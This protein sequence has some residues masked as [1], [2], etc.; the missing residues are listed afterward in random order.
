MTGFPSSRVREHFLVSDDLWNFR[1]EHERFRRFLRPTLHSGLGWRP[2]ERAVH[3]DCVE[4]LGVICQI[5]TFRQTFGVKGA[6]PA[7]SGEGG[8]A[9]ANTGTGIVRHVNAIV[10]QVSSWAITAKRRLSG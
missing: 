9:K 2:V 6:G 3:L 8:C 10:A 4:V 1:R 5:F 7:R